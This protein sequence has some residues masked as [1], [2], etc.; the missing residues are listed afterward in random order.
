MLIQTDKYRS[1]IRRPPTPAL[2]PSGSNAHAGA[3]MPRLTLPVA[4]RR[5]EAAATILNPY[6]PR[7]TPQDFQSHAAFYRYFYASR[8]VPPFCSEL[9]PNHTTEYP[10]GDV[11]GMT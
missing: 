11:G 5:V 7:R 10:Q 4:A 9:T 3:M 2:I 8:G 6:G 1:H